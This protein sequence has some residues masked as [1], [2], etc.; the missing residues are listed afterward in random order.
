MKTIKKIIVCI[1]SIILV[2]LVLALTSSIC[3]SNLITTN[4]IKEGIKQ[5]ILT[6]N[7]LDKGQTYYLYCSFGMQSAKACAT[8]T[9]MGY[10]VVNV[11]GGYHDYVSK[12]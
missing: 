7:Y 11:L 10:K 2:N 1:L 8:L 9:N 4:L 3:V 12:S 5:Q 6:E